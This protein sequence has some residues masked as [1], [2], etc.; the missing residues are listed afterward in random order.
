LALSGR[1]PSALP[2]Q[3]VLCLGAYGADW[4]RPKPGHVERA[5]DGGGATGLA[6]M[7][8]RQIGGR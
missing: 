7:T 8:W 2:E 4:R 1:Y 3:S 5:L 6:V